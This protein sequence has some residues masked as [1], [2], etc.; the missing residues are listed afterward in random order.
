MQQIGQRQFAWRMRE[1][2]N[3]AFQESKE[4]PASELEDALIELSEHAEEY[5][6]NLET[7]VAPYIVCA[8]LFG[9]DFDIN[10]P[11]VRS[12]LSDGDM[13]ALDKAEWLWDFAEEG[14]DILEEETEGL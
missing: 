2:L 11:F 7:E 3:E 8:W 12:L 14:I 6:L 1:I 9:F 10:F 5:G 13:S 4:I